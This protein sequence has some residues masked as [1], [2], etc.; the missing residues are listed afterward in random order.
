[1]QNAAR[2]VHSPEHPV[3]SQS[4][5]FSHIPRAKGRGQ[6]ARQAVRDISQLVIGFLRTSCQD[7]GTDRGCLVAQVGPEFQQFAKSFKCS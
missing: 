4:G 1:M 5:G 7:K 3:P 2:D 6:R